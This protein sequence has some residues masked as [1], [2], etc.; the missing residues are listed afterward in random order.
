[1]NLNANNQNISSN[2]LQVNG[3]TSLQS[4]DNN[5]NNNSES[6]IVSSNLITTT[7]FSSSSPSSSSCDNNN[8]I[9]STS[10]PLMFN[11]RISLT[12]RPAIRIRNLNVTYGHS[13]STEF[14]LNNVA[15]TA[16]KGCIYGL[17]GPSGCGKTTL[18]KCLMGLKIPDSGEISIFNYSPGTRESGVPGPG[19]GYMP[20]ETALSRDLTIKETWTFFGRVN[21]LTFD[22]ISERISSLITLLDLPDKNTLI[23]S[24]SGGQQRR[25]SFGVTILHNPRLLILDEPTVGVDPLLR[26][27]IWRQ[28]TNTARL[29]GSTIIV[30]THYIE[31]TRKADVVGFMRKGAIIAEN[32]P[33]AFMSRYGVNTLE[34]VFHHLCYIHKRVS[35][36]GS[37]KQ[38]SSKEGAKK[39][40]TINSKVRGNNNDS[41]TT[42]ATLSAPWSRP[43]ETSDTHAW[44]IQFV[45]TLTKYN[46]QIIRQPETIVASLVLPIII[47]LVFCVCIGG[48]PN[49][50]PIGLVNHENCDYTTHQINDHHQNHHQKHHHHQNHHHHEH[51]SPSPLGHNAS[52]FYF[53]NE[54][55]LS[56]AFLSSINSYMFSKR[57]YADYVDA[58]DDVASGHIWGVVRIK[59]GF[60]DSLL[61]RLTFQETDPFTGT[62]I[63]LNSSTIEIH[64]DLTSFVLTRL[65]TGAL[66]RTFLDT[67]KP[68]LSNP[69]LADLPIKLGSTVFGS[70][71]KSDFFGVRDFAA[72]GLMIVIVYS[73]GFALTAFTLL[74]EKEDRTLDRNYSA[75][76]GA[77]QIILG[78]VVTRFIFLIPPVV[79]LLT[80][81]IT[82]FGVP[83]RGSFPFAILLLLLQMLSGMSLGVFLSTVLPSIFSCAIVAN[84]VLLFT[85]IISGVMWS[86]DT[87]PY[88]LRWV[89]VTQPTT[90]AAESLRSILV[91]GLPIAQSSVFMGYVTSAAWIGVWLTLGTLSFAFQNS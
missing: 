8:Q 20:Q 75:G 78:Q 11:G 85:F 91:R 34:A 41:K 42:I 15:M 80:L 50:V 47:L 27:R 59:K 33:N 12:A 30:T 52:D 31:E 6:L 88:Y 26:S 62:S 49:G 68:T 36:S 63:D 5:N 53:S 18:I 51:H 66:G 40:S 16:P 79:I 57:Y 10:S 23:S 84:A 71:G 35:L 89:S 69:K 9:S 25:V 54:R 17:L 48:T 67:I 77:F 44:W 43:N 65:V 7:S 22:Q 24:L 72:P 21:F 90:A 14:V 39:K 60:T 38:I 64:G 46:L 32:S 86:I 1:M 19:V 29:Y 2:K 82:L 74:I 61:A 55:C 76:L 70:F 4:D 45:A 37:M 28:L 83:C 3:L 73:I 58:L 13:G 87:L 81:S 56:S